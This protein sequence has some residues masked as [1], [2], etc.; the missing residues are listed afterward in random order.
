MNERLQ[1][2]LCPLQTTINSPKPLLPLERNLSD[3]QVLELYHSGR[4]PY[5]IAEEADEWLVRLYAN[6]PERLKKGFKLQ[7]IVCACEQGLIK[8]TAE[9]TLV[10][11][12]ES[13]ILLAYLVGRLCCGDKVKVMKT[14]Q[15]RIWVKGSK[16]FPSREIERL[17]GIHKLA[18][19]RR[20]DKFQRVPKGAEIIDALI[21]TSGE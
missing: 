9:G 5:V 1:G 14:T 11:L 4:I 15:T 18:N 21:V 20:R 10:W 13:K 3:E 12:L 17:F 7:M 16:D 6:L 8:P 2:G 19:N